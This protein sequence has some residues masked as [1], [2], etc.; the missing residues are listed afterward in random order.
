MTGRLYIDGKDAYTEYGVYV[1]RGGWN[2]L[3]AYP[4]LKA[5]ESNDWQ[6]KDGIEVDLSAPVL[7]TREVS[8]KF[9]IAS[10]DDHFF[11]FIALLSDSAYHTFDCRYIRRTYKLRLVSLSNLAVAQ[12][13]GVTT[14]KF[15]DD[16][17]LSGYTYTAPE[18]NILAYNDYIFDDVKFTDYGVRILKGTLDEVMKIPTVK[19]NLLRNI[20]TQAGAIYDDKN[21]T[22]KSKDVK[23][24]CLMRAETLEELWRNYDAL[25]YDLTRPEEHILKVDRLDK[26]F[27]FYYKSCQVSEFYPTDKIWLQFTLIVTFITP[28]PIDAFKSEYEQLTYIENTSSAFIDTGYIFKHFDKK[29]EIRF[30]QTGDIVNT[31]LFG[32]SS[33]QNTDYVLN[34]FG[35]YTVW[36]GASPYTTMAAT[37]GKTYDY[38]LQI[39]NSILTQTV[40][41]AAST[42]TVPDVTA[43]RSLYLFDVNS[44][45]RLSFYSYALIRLFG[46]KIY[47][48]EAPVRDYIPAKR[49]SDGAIGLFDLIECKFYTSPNGVEFIGG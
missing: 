45:N 2:E 42:A 22:Y 49:K 29:V 24:N 17:P 32:A 13:L 10:F 15:A 14:L 3:I 30:Q 11:A 28:N 35:G 40:D 37:I 27:S 36:V 9:A 8:I 33:N 6:E 48:G 18:S 19:T 20:N 46:A 16:F 41:G 34:P 21:V 31:H 26:K 1:E 47:D 12:A 23:I 44:G 38:A 7:D 25:L 43:E 4:S 39:K 5:V